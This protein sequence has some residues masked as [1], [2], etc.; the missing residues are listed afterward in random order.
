MCRP[1]LP[2]GLVHMGIALPVCRSS[3]LG[4]SGACLPHNALLTGI[5]AP[6]DVP[7]DGCSIPYGSSTPTLQPQIH[8][9]AHEPIRTDNERQQDTKRWFA[10]TVS[11]K[12]QE[13]YETPL[14]VQPP[15]HLR[16]GWLSS[17][18][19]PPPPAGWTSADGGTDSNGANAAYLQMPG[20][21][22]TPEHSESGQSSSTPSPYDWPP[23]PP[24]VCIASEWIGSAPQRGDTAL[25]PTREL[26]SGHAPSSDA[27]CK[28]FDFDAVMEQACLGLR[29]ARAVPLTGQATFCRLL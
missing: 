12:S 21:A 7:V 15:G 14:G 27:C 10:R 25:S 2:P 9:E 5:A 26:V 22:T 3:S 29:V 19:M 6:A 1:I 8:A 16:S 13:S 28:Y 23:S 18:S 11:C 17:L 24:L 4:S 20:D